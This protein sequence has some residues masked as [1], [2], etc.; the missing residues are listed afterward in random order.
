MYSLS[1]Q[2]LRFFQCF[3]V[4][5]CFGEV[6]SEIRLRE[7]GRTQGKYSHLGSNSDEKY[8]QYMIIYD[9]YM[10]GGITCG[11]IEEAS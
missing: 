11:A 2:E 5:L 7:W 9:T 6:Q 3:R 1:T 4:L 10:Q 8:I